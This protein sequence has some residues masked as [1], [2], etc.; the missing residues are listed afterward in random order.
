MPV[1]EVHDPAPSQ[2]VH[3]QTRPT[4]TTWLDHVAGA[5]PHR[6]G[7]ENPVNKLRAAGRRE[8]AKLPSGS[9]GIAHHQ[10]LTDLETCLQILRVED[11]GA[12]MDRRSQDQ[13]IPE[14]ER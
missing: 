1:E 11:A 10:A 5:A 9:E 6:T 8:R 7:I 3:S 2:R 4:N 12:T 14:R 13:A